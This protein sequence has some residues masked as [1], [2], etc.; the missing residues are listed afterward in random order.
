MSVFSF[1]LLIILCSIKNKMKNKLND[2]REFED[3][4]LQ[5]KDLEVS[6]VV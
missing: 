6:S 5:L 1:P 2:A 4:I 3:Q